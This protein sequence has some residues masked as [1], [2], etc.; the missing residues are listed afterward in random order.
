LRLLSAEQFAAGS[1]GLRHPVLAAFARHAPGAIRNVATHMQVLDTGVH[2]FPVSVNDGGERIDNSYVVSPLT[3]YCGYAQYELA[4]LGHA[5]LTWPLRGLVRA[6][7][8]WL[9]SARIDRLVHV[10]NWLLSTNVYPGDWEGADLPEMTDLLMRAF[11][12][13]ALCFRSLNPFINAGL[14]ERLTNLGYLAIPSRQVYLFDA[15][16]GEEASFLRRHNSRI[17][18]ALLRK[19]PYRLVDGSDLGEEDYARLAH[20]YSLLYLQK[21][22]P[23]NPQFSADWLRAGQRD[24]WLELRAL[25]S[26]AGSIDGVLGWFGN[27]Q[28]LTAPV[29]GYDT[30]LPQQLGLYRLITRQCLQEAV[31]RRCLL[32]F[33]SGA[34]H[35]KRMRGGE[36]AIEYSMVY[37]RHLPAARRQV[38]HALGRLLHGLGV[39]MMRTLKL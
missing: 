29:V 2:A 28:V 6:M 12:E 3:T 35:F 26:E 22:S 17:D 13:H 1:G 9:A 11:P 19:S 30:A 7:G 23:L 39:P 21:Y 14:I 31:R 4:Q 18:A 15:R 20:L 25:R 33:S 10:N 16:A 24:G 36:P 37:V 5:W 34:A 8:S 38:W 32:N 27:A